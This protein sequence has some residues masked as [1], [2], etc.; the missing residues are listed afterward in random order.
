MVVLE[1][2]CARVVVAFVSVSVAYW[3]EADAVG[4]VAAA[5]ERMLFSAAVD[6]YFSGAS[7][8]SGDVYRSAGAV[9]CGVGGALHVDVRDAGDPPCFG[10]DDG[11]TAAVFDRDG[12]HVS[13]GG[14]LFL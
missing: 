11:A 12:D 13:G 8:D 1:R 3:A 7:S 9:R 5:A 14:G 10:A 2:A 4:V 6:A